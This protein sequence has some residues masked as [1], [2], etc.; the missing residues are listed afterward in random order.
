VFAPNFPAELGGTPPEGGG[1]MFMDLIHLYE[2][3]GGGSG[4]ISASWSFTMSIALPMVVHHGSP[5]LKERVAKPVIAGD[6][7]I[8]LAVTEPWG[9][10]DVANVRTTAVEDGDF[11]IVNG[12]KKFITSGMTANFFTTAV[13]TYATKTGMAGLSVLIIDANS[14]GITRTKI[15]TQGWWAGNTAYITFENVRVPKANLVGREGHGFRY[16]ME[17]FNH[18]RWA[19]VV[20]CSAG[21]HKLIEE[22]VKYARGRKTFGKALIENQVIR[23]KIAMMAMRAEATFAVSEQLAYFMETGVPAADVAARIALAK[24]QATQSLEF[25][26]REASQ[27][28]GG[29]SYMRGGPGA[30]VERQYREVRVAAIGGGSEE[31][32]LDFAVR[33]S[34]L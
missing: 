27:I 33:S 1:D 25:C 18:E 3:A 34:K 23:Q 13:R 31:I 7:V 15:K 9:G 2:V 29:N 20:M 10:S 12:E 5:A 32:L 4:G 21:M 8:A 26:A 28:L 19:A 6:A 22:S 24:V 30:T 14:P 11:Y 17:N 16:I